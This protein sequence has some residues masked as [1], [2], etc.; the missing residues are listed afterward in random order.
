MEDAPRSLLAYAD[1]Q[2][3][4]TTTAE[5]ALA[6]A[7][8]RLHVSKKLKGSLTK[9]FNVEYCKAKCTE[10]GLVYEE[11]RNRNGSVTLDVRQTDPTK[12]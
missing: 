7:C 12:Y 10:Q 8:R 4:P 11:C 5:K 2:T 6:N 1:K 3:A 9:Y